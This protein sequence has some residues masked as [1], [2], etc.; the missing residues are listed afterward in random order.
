MKTRRLASDTVSNWVSATRPGTRACRIERE[1]KAMAA[2][3]F[4]G[5]ANLGFRV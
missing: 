5:R 4:V 2:L 3:V 1:L